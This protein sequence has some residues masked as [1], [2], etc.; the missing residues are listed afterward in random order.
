VFLVK[1]INAFFLDCYGA[2]NSGLNEWCL[3]RVR[4]EQIDGLRLEHCE[5][6]WM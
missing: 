4:R 1:C 6:F 3:S 2:E 5:T